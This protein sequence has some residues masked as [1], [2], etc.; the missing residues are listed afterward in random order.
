MRL[1]WVNSLAH[2]PSLILLL[3]GQMV[4]R[5]AAIGFEVPIVEQV[6]HQDTHCRDDEPHI[7]VAFN[8]VGFRN[9]WAK[10]ETYR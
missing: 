2:N 9:G 5:D 1:D 10:N 4:V 7:P 3:D 6:Y 8:N